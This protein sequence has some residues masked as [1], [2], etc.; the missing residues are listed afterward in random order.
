[1]KN[2]NKL[3]L[4][5]AVL[6]FTTATYADTVSYAIHNSCTNKIMAAT[7]DS[8]DNAA[9]E[10]TH[11][12]ANNSFKKITFDK[13]GKIIVAWDIGENDHLSKLGADI[14]GSTG[15]SF[16]MQ[17]NGATGSYDCMPDK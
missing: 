15:S 12:I 1:M 6:T 3:I 8:N 2:F 14:N 9:P 4:T 10:T 11:E 5:A 13:E 16:S 7:M 17:Y